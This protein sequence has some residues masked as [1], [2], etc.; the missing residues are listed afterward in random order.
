MTA[1]T[2]LAVV[3]GGVAGL[4]AAVELHH[5]SAGSG[6]EVLLF[7]RDGRTGGRV[8][9]EVWEGRAVDL[10]AES[11]LVR[12]PDTIAELRD[13]GLEPQL[14][15]PATT[16]A[17]IWTGHRLVPI[18]RETVLGVPLHPLRRDVVRLLGPWPAVRASFEPYLRGVPLGPDDPLGPFL[19]SRLGP[20][21]FRRA[22]EPLIGGVYAAPAERL[23]IGVVA[24]SLVAAAASG[25][26][27]L[28]GL[29]RHRV[30]GAGGAAF[31]TFEQ[32]LVA[33]PDALRSALPPASVRTGEEVSAVEPGRQRALRL[34]LVGGPDIDVDGVVVAI[35]A[36]AAGDLVRPLSSE[37]AGELRRQRYSSV[38]TVTLAYRD[39]AF[40]TALRGSGFLVPRFR[41]R[42]VT[43]C[44]F[45]DRKWP[46]LRQPGTTLLRA[47]AGSLGEEWVLG[48]DD[49]ALVTSVHAQLRRILGLK[50]LPFAVRVQRWQPAL[51]QYEAGHIAWRARVDELV[52]NLHHPVTLV[53]SSYNG[54]GLAACVGDGRGGARRL[55]SL[56]RESGPSPTATI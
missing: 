28:R 4:A 24:P 55:W 10:G 50:A 18:P 16:S 14:L 27:L 36:P 9:T 33:L 6:G 30:Q 40:A 15:R 32:G 38:A 20:V 19:R 26:S 42:V 8:L 51:A 31:I 13:L 23:S 44:T 17:S 2:R 12:S 43:A 41:G 52:T 34:R 3:G 22:V 48:L 7:E 35:P 53:G 29:R 11:M 47:S 39:S 5:A 1:S 21:A 54:V 56:L 45:L 46:H 49:A 37:L 25:T